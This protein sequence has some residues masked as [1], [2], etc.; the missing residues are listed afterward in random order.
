MKEREREREERRKGL[1]SNTIAM[2]HSPVETVVYRPWQIIP[3]VSPIILFFY[4][5]NFNLLF[6]PIILEAY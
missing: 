6:S 5:H 2:T 3:N 4:S 1:E